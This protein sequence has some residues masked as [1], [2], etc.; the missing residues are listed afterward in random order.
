MAKKP[1]SIR[2]PFSGAVDREGPPLVPHTMAFPSA[3]MSTQVLMGLPHDTHVIGAH[4]M[5]WR[6]DHDY[7]MSLGLSGEGFRFFFDAAEYARFELPEGITPIRDCFDYAGIPVRIHTENM[8]RDADGMW[9]SDDA[10]KALV[11]GNLRG[12]FPCLLLGRASTDQVMLAIG[13]EDHGETLVAWTFIPGGDMTN[14][15][16]SPEDC[17]FL[18]NWEQKADAVVLVRGRP[19]EPEK[20]EEILL[21][22]LDRG[23]TFLREQRGAPYGSPVQYYDHWVKMLNDDGYWAGV[24]EGCPFIY[25]EIWDLAERRAYSASFL[26]QAGDRLKTSA[27]EPGVEA[28]NEIHTNMW[29][30]HAL[31]DGENSLEKL[32]DRAVRMRITEII[33]ACRRLDEKTAEAIRSYRGEVKLFTGEGREKC[34]KS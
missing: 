16:F 19:Q 34:Q 4:N 1:A 2:V 13:Y 33:E 21:R 6:A 8:I 31:I 28:L 15:S 11:L 26:E 12:G 22:A 5:K 32:K 9:A 30:I 3:V 18:S 10:L 24:K 27:L 25:P 29:K 23:E 20:R 7:N 17:Q 14:K